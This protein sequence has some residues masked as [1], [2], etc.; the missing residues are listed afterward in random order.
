MTSQMELH[1][2]QCRIFQNKDKAPVAITYANDDKFYKNLDHYVFEG[3]KLDVTFSPEK[4]TENSALL[5]RMLS[6]FN[7]QDLINNCESYYAAMQEILTFSSQQQ[8]KDT[9]EKCLAA[10][11]KIYHTYRLHDFRLTFFHIQ[12]FRFCIF[13]KPSRYQSINTLPCLPSQR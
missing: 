11:N 3:H 7:G 2:Q 10:D 9:L 5:E 8:F 13:S 4:L 1:L 6:C 12:I